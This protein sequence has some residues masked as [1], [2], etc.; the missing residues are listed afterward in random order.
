[1][2]VTIDKIRLISITESKPQRLV[3]MGYFPDERAGPMLTITWTFQMTVADAEIVRLA[4]SYFHG[5][6]Q[7][8]AEVTEV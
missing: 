4:Q 7:K 2:A 1:M 6:C 3:T 5:L 8:L